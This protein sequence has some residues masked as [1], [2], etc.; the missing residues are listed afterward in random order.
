MLLNRNE[1][2]QGPSPACLRVLRGFPSER[3]AFYFD[4]YFGSILIPA[5]SGIFKIPEQQIM[6]GYGL[7][8]ILRIIFDGLNPLSDVVLTN[9]FH[10]TYYD[11]YLIFKNIRLENFKLI[12]NNRNFVFDVDDCAAQAKKIRPKVILITS[13]NNPTGHSI[14]A[15]DLSK[16]IE[17]AG[18]NAFIVL[19]EAYYGFDN[20]YDEA[21]FL[22]L[23]KKHKNLMLLRSFSKLYALAGLRVGFALCGENV[24]NTLRYQDLYLGGSRILEE[25]AVAA[26]ESKRYYQGLAKQIISDR[27][28]FIQQTNRLRHFRA[29]DSKANFVLVKTDKNV[30]P[31]LA[32]ELAKMNCAI[33]KFVSNE[34]MRVSIG[35][36]RYTE[37]FTR[38]LEK[39][40]EQTR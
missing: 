8:D 27:E 10:F 17:S 40:D 13:P 9:E 36:K 37:M 39:A 25:A 21:G 18:Q 16:I 12:E 26:L 29:Y 6:L 1:V 22:S 34:F 14:C 19:D 15:D 28:S 5:L 3:A 33:S 4:G 30:R 7:E 32:K 20:S 23:F 24:K 2:I 11:K 31:A 35:M 38:V